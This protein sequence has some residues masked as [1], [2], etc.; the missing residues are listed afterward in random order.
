M[1]ISTIK[2]RDVLDKVM[3]KVEARGAID[4]T[5]RLKQ[6]CGQMFQYAV[7]TGSEERDV[8]QDLKG[9]L[10][11]VITKHYLPEV[12][13]RFVGAIS[14]ALRNYRGPSGCKISQTR[15]VS[16]LCKPAAICSQNDSLMSR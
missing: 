11:T 12:D 6:L 7:T 15:A 5:H 9:A 13:P 10:S 8:T 4:T 1:P 2:L 16:S 3:R 14:P